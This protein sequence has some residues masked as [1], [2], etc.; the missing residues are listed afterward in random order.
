MATNEE[1]I[2]RRIQASRQA[3]VLRMAAS[4]PR[5]PEAYRQ[6]A[7][8]MA[9]LE[10]ETGAEVAASMAAGTNP[11]VG[12]TQDLYDIGAGAAT[13]DPVRTV[14]GLGGLALP[15]ATGAQIRVGSRTLSGRAAEIFKDLLRRSPGSSRE[16]LADVAQR[17]AT[18]EAEKAASV[19]RRP[20][21]QEGIASLVPEVQP[22]SF[23]Q[24]LRNRPIDD[25]AAREAVTGRGDEFAAGKLEVVD[26]AESPTQE[27]MD[28]ALQ[29]VMR[30]VSDERSGN[31]FD[32]V[33]QRALMTSETAAEAAAAVRRQFPDMSDAEF[34]E[35]FASAVAR[36][37][38]TDKALESGRGITSLTPLLLDSSRRLATAGI[39]VTPSRQKSLQDLNPQPQRSLREQGAGLEGIAPV[40]GRGLYDVETLQAPVIAE[41]ARPLRRI[42]FLNEPTEMDFAASKIIQRRAGMIDMDEVP[43]RHPLRADPTEELLP[44][45]GLYDPEDVGDLRTYREQLKE[46]YDEIPT[47]LDFNSIVNE[48]QDQYPNATRDELI[49]AVTNVLNAMHSDVAISVGRETLEESGKDAAKHLMRD[50]DTGRRG[51]ISGRRRNLIRREK[52]EEALRRKERREAIKETFAGPEIMEAIERRRLRE[53]ERLKQEAFERAYSGDPTEIFNPLG[54]YVGAGSRT[55]KREYRLANPDWRKGLLTIPQNR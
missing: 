40:E 7:R 31:V 30:G 29:S 20:P 51:E 12:L 18:V 42:D 32:Y 9:L 11:L 44:V 24:P 14:F 36:V 46:V 53:T 27:E 1:D 16:E 23:G 21:Q 38:E 17:R 19:A 5:S 54:Q 8:L 47:G 6:R 25:A 10:P 49:R 55:P 33:V 52:A 26:R 13:R 4:M 3:D 48:L 50:V 22:E 39:R 34:A 41:A 37:T 28:S 2:L 35:R 15:F 45:E 43:A